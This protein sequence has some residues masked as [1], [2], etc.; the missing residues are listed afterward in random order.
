[1][2]VVTGASGH[3]GG[4]LVRALLERGR[5]VRV[6]LHKDDRALEG[7]EVETVQGDIRDIDFLKYIFKGADVVYHAAGHISLL[8]ND[9][10][11]L[12]SVNVL[13]TRNVVEACLHSKVRRLVHF[14]SIHALVQ[15]PLDVPVDESRPL[16]ESKNYPPYDRSKAAGEK[17]IIKGIMRGLNAVIINPT[18]I[19]GPNDFRPSHV[20]KV[21][22]ALAQRKLPALVDGGFNW[23][24][25][26]DVVEGAIR[27]E[28]IAISG[29]RYLLSGHWISV[30]E[31]ARLV[32]QI[33]NIRP[34]R[35]ICPMWLARFGA[36]LT[37]AFSRIAGKRPIYTTVSLKALISNR[38]ISHARATRELG[39]HPRPFRKTI[40][41]TLKWFSKKGYLACDVE[42]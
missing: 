25:I 35:I 3:V 17:E 4:N 9:W 28:K 36:P 29:A 42:Y 34:L 39:Y 19:I 32:E 21:L 1:M 37:T 31:M 38:V 15:E 8:M 16:V 13:G 14:S 22:L 30:K 33:T 11:L 23:V 5:S 10:P 12:E 27:A 2:I 20:G 41:D 26:R 40:T 7:L 18:G 6:L 24:D